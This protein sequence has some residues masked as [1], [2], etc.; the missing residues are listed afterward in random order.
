MTTTTTTYKTKLD[1]PAWPRTAKNTAK[2]ALYP[3]TTH[4]P[5]FDPQI[6]AKC[7]FTCAM[8]VIT[9]D[10]GRRAA[11]PRWPSRSGATHLSRRT[12]RRGPGSGCPRPW[13]RPGA[14]TCTTSS[15]APRKGRAERSAPGRGV[16]GLLNSD[17][18]GKVHSR[19]SWW[20]GTAVGWSG[21]PSRA[22]EGGG[23]FWRNN[24]NGWRQVGSF[25]LNQCKG[26]RL[27]PSALRVAHWCERQRWCSF[28]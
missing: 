15:N 26:A 16:F 6:L 14:R 20:A 2:L 12:W 27:A 24:H 1:R 9:R 5:S 23:N 7:A 4:T 28:F 13:S 10:R 21:I 3:Q 17:L 25:T 22:V 8:T 19:Q 11:T 18:G